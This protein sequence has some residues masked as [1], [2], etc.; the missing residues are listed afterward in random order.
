MSSS[1]KARQRITA[2]LDENSFVE[3]GAKVTARATDFNLK[4]EQTPS[5]GV[6]TGYGVIDGNLVYVYSQDASVLGGSVGEMHAKKIAA[7]YDLAIRTGAPVVGLVES[8]GLRLQEGMDALNAFGTIYARQVKASGLIPQITAI[9]GNCGGGL[10]L[11]P[12]L[13][14]FAFMANDAKLFVNA[15][16]TLAGNREDKNDTA[17]A[18]VK[19]ACGSVDAAGT[20][21]EIIDQIRTLVSMLPSNNEDE[22]V[23]ECTDDLNRASENVAAGIADPSI[24]LGDIADDGLFF[25]TKRECAPEMATGFIRLNGATV[26]AVANRSVSYDENGEEKASYETVLTASGCYK[27]ADFVR[28]CDAFEIPV[29]TL[30]NVTGFA[31]TESEEKKVADAAGKL[32]AAFAGAN[33]PKVNVITGKAIGSAYAV[34]NS[35][36]SGADFTIAFPDATIGM[37]DAKL[38]AHVLCTGSAQEVAETAAKYDALQNSIDSAAARGYVDQIIEPEDLRKYLIGAMEVL[39]TKREEFPA[40][41]KE[42]RNMK[43]WL[44][45]TLL[46][47]ACVFNLVACGSSE[48]NS[49]ASSEVELT[50]E[51]QQQWYDSAS[52]FVLSMNDAVATGQ[53]EAQMDDPIYGPAFSSWE[54]AL[55]DIGEIQ[56][57]E[58]NSCSFTKK[59]GRVT[60]TVKG[61][62]HDADVVFTMESSDQ[63]YSVTGIT[64]NVIYS[65]S[66]K[67][68]QAALNTLLGMGTTFAV[69]ILLALVIALFG[70]IVGGAS[71]KPAKSKAPAQSAPAAAAAIPAAVEEEELADD[72]ELVAVIA[73]AVAAFEGK[74]STDGFVVRSIRKARRK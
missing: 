62:K 25:E 10:A 73:A 26:G 52:Q 38:A 13:T 35:K 12:A 22:A 71:K 66:E 59:E 29:I 45:T 33:V 39:Y 64:T 63:G 69:L 56:G 19:A 1:S 72:M 58:G 60:V 11:I 55:V 32:T 43:K 42:T 54:N 37:M 74:Q 21:E 34:M 2:L 30:T 70:R 7:I 9:F 5:D 23:S 27:A 28:F 57:I 24:V 16:N 44:I 6:I 48:N 53:A 61:S 8:A 40:S 68:Q 36:A 46:V 15:P 67:I 4:P 20:E 3:I 18:S 50:E 47:I 14:D 41:K 49:T 31:A 65:M 51:Q 17:A